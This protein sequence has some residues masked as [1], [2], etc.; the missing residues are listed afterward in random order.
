M[1]IMKNKAVTISYVL[2]NENS[3][4]IEQTT[5]DKPLA[6]LFGVGG[7]LPDFEAHLLGLEKGNSF[8]FEIKSNRAY[9]E[10]DKSAVVDLPIETFVFDGKLAEDM[11][12]VGKMI[13]MRNDQK[14]LIHGKIV[15]VKKGEEK[16][17]M[18]FNHPLA[19]VDL[20]FTG[21]VLEVREATAE[22]IAH[23]HVHG[24]GGHQ[25]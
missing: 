6:F 23:G 17:I 18:D 4:L 16:V 22:E 24:L 7:M 8:D 5:P 1:V 13:P 14:Q 3:T 11:L 19:G 2:R 9:G 15:E 10:V 25:H 12:V 20:H 21:K